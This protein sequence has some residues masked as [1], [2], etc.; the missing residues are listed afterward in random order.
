MVINKSPIWKLSCKMS[1]LE[2]KEFFDNL[3]PS[4]DKKQNDTEE[5]LKSFLSI[6]NIKKG[7]AILDV[8]CGTGKISGILY[9]LSSKDVIGIDISKNMIDIAK[10]KYKDNPHVKFINEDFTLSNYSSYD[11][12]VIFN[13]YPHFLD[14]DLLSEVLYNSLKEGGRVSIVHNL[15]RQQLDSHHSGEQVKI[16]SRFLLPVKQEANQ[17]SSKFKILKAEE[18]D[19][20]YFIQLQK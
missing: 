9:Q 8:G 13:A 7:E 17:F 15:S 14:V 12:I 18:D 4:W 20:H 6:L 19:K 16:V 10:E 3:A 5:G 1:N 2:I 11:H